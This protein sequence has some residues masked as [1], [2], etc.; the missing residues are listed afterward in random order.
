MENFEILDSYKNKNKWNDLIKQSQFSDLD[1]YYSPDYINLYTNN[2]NQGL[3][4]YYTENNKK[5]FIPFL[6]KKIQIKNKIFNNFYD[7]ETPYG[8]GG[9]IN[10]CR[11]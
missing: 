6:K 3:M 11:S 1:I 7:L 10:S 4:F 8:Y 5:W 9:P 2:L